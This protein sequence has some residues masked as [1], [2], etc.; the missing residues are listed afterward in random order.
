M[1]NKF[2]TMIDRLAERYITACLKE[3]KDKI[4]SIEDIM[5]TY[6]GF[7]YAKTVPDAQMIERIKARF[8]DIRID[9]ERGII[10]GIDWISPTAI[11]PKKAIEFG[12]KMLQY[13]LKDMLHCVPLYQ[14]RG[15][16][17]AE[18]A[19]WSKDSIVSVGVISVYKKIAIGEALDFLDS[20]ESNCEK[21][22]NN[23]YH[24]LGE[25]NDL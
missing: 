4:V 16:T 1:D 21:R 13:R 10:T 12:I 14:T 8:P 25:I 5:R 11:E 6:Q 15:F 24:Y 7:S 2:S 19:G 9:L 3:A 20:G 23:M 17:A 22:D 18:F